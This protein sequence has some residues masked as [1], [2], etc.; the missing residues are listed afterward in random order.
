M[1]QNGS[2]VLG[3]IFGDDMRFKQ[4]SITGTFFLTKLCQDKINVNQ[5]SVYFLNE[6]YIYPIR[7]ISLDSLYVYD[8]I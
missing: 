1:E 8:N 7:T 6:N 5:N 3:D 4:N 2:Q